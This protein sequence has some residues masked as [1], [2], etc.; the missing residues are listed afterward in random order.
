MA[1][2][3]NVP[4]VNPRA[5]DAGTKLVEL[6]VMELDVVWLYGMTDVVVVL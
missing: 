5:T 6:S 3:L 2:V 1:R 4:S